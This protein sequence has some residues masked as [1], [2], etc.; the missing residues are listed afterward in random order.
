MFSESKKQRHA[1]RQGGT[2]RKTDSVT[3]IPFLK[4][5]AALYLPETGR[6][7]DTE[8]MEICLKN[9]NAVIVLGGSD[10][11]T[12]VPEVC[13][14][15][16]AEQGIPA[17]G[18]RYW[19]VPG[20]PM[21]LRMVPVESVGA[22]ADWLLEHGA[23]KVSLYGFSTGAELALL[24]ASRMP[25]IGGV[26]AV[27]PSA[28]VWGSE[29]ES[30]FSLRGR[31]LPHLSQK[32]TGAALR[33]SLRHLQPEGRTIYQNPIE[34]GFIDEI[35]IPVENIR[36]SILFLYPEND[37]VWPSREAS[38]YMENRLRGAGFPHPVRSFGY[39]HASHLLAPCSSLHRFLYREERKFPEKC[40]RS[41][42]DAF[43]KAT[44]WIRGE[45]Q[46]K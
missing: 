37:P 25:Q 7:A 32:W 29:D 23:E 41:R 14:R 46:Q 33:D 30:E 43:R 44:A 20:L 27:S 35:A 40:D 42:R 9:R 31:N 26:V 5:Q 2:S 17:L 19:G 12:T 22:A 36:G 3:R 45:G 18:M 1:D 11:F 13:G 4:R 24:A 21:R 8:N 28:V 34:E 10:R 15:L 16:F 38:V 6:Q 39:K